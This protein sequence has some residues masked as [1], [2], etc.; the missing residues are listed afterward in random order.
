VFRTAVGLLK[1]NART[2]GERFVL[3]VFFSQVPAQDEHA[4]VVSA[5]GHVRF[6]S[7][8]MIPRPMEVVA[9]MREGLPNMYPRGCTRRARH[10]PMTSP[11]HR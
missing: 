7:M 4:L 2:Y 1:G 3:S 6:A 8:L 10:W 9:V 11:S 5:S